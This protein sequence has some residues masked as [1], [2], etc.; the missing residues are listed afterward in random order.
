MINAHTCHP[1]PSSCQVNNLI[2]IS[3]FCLS[4][5]YFEDCPWDLSNSCVVVIC[6]ISSNLLDIAILS[7]ASC[8]HQVM[9]V[10]EASFKV[11][12]VEPFSVRIQWTSLAIHEKMSS[13]ILDDIDEVIVELWFVLIKFF[14]ILINSVVNVWNELLKSFWKNRAFFKS[15]SAPVSQI[16]KHCCYLRRGSVWKFGILVCWVW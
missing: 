13:K 4:P 8:H 14:M 5:R 3:V 12:L 11:N 1:H 10:I 9:I 16:P 15:V 2:C 6:V 7:K